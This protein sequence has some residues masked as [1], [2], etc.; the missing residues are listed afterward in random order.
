MGACLLSHIVTYECVA[1]PKSIVEIVAETLSAEISP[2]RT[3]VVSGAF[4]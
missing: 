1:R 4:E 2:G 3:L